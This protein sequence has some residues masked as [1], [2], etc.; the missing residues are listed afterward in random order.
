[1]VLF[2][3]FETYMHPQII[4]WGFATALLAGC[5]TERPARLATD[6]D[7][8]NPNAPEA[9]IQQAFAFSGSPS[10]DETNVA[11]PMES[12]MPG[13]KHDMGGMTGMKHDMSNM[14]PGAPP[15]MPGM[16]RH[17]MPMDA[18]AT[19]PAETQPAGTEGAL[20]PFTCTMHPQVLSTQPGKC[21]ICGMKLVK[22]AA[23]TPGRDNK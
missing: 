20:A 2:P 15:T 19:A 6:N 5:A 22:K 12:S 23:P 18:P 7:P 4:G 10:A 14:S 11:P 1:L 16:S 21:P 8:T 13:M 3:S 17:E 9:P